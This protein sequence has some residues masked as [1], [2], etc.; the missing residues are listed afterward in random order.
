[1]KIPEIK[2][3]N[4]YPLNCWDPY[5]SASFEQLRTKWKTVPTAQHRINTTDL[6][7]LSDSDLVKYWKEQVHLSTTGDYFNVRGWYHKLYKPILRGCKV[8]DVGAGLGIDGLS[9]A[10]AGADVT[11]LDIVYDNTEITSRLISSLG[12]QNQARSVYMQDLNSLSELLID[13]YDFIWCQGSLINAPYDFVCKEIVVLLEH[14]PVGGRWIE[15]AYPKE[16]WLREGALNFQEWGEKT[17]GENTPWVEWYDLD[18]L[19][20]AL[21][22]AEFAVVLSFNFHNDDFNWFDLMRI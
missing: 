1:M 21:K 8:L 4:P 5:D 20:Q 15:L 7:V 22:P 16:R 18:K 6:H 14:L 19:L 13:D 11:L 10:Q 9:F 3:D 17:D 12:I 2:I